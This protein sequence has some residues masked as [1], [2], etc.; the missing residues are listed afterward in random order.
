M[1]F[2]ILTQYYPP[3]TG[4]PQNRLSDM[5]QRL[6]AMGHDVRVLTAKPNYPRGCFYPGFEK[7]LWKHSTHDGVR[8]THCW[9]YPTRSK[10]ILFRLLN[11]LSFVVSAAII[12]SFA[13]PVADVLIVESPPLFLSITGWWLSHLK[14]ARMILNVSDL[15][16]ET[17]ISLGLLQ[18]AW[19]QKLFYWFEAWSYS[20]SS[21]VTGQTGGIVNSV[22][23]RFPNKTVYWLPNG[24][25]LEQFPIKEKQQAQN[26]DKFII[27][28]AG[29]LGYAQDLDTVLEAARLLQEQTDIQFHFYGDGPLHDSFGEKADELGLENVEILG[30]RSHE[31]I[32]SLM[33]TWDVG[34][35][36]LAD[37]PLMAGAL[38]SKMFEMMGA[39]LPIL[40][41]APQGEASALISRAKA[42]IWVEAGSPRTLAD[43]IR[44]LRRDRKTCQQLG[45]NGMFYVA[46]HFDRSKIVENFISFLTR[47]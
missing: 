7:G 23:R 41:S 39:G 45:R 3:E 15:Y 4:A 31:E 18:Q 44:G 33:Q 11:Y 9:L 10:R 8:V 38:P 43:A 34:F 28:Y 32:V 16:P 20:V 12:G 42:G 14:S 29:I 6:V 5:A 37:V 40:L 22:R 24:V 21:L 36:P 30:H 27:G 47:V 1:R 13:L 35:V 2:V 17:A 46:Q 25:D 26:H 19:L